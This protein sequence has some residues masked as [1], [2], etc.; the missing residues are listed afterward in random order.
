MKWTI[1]GSELD[2]LIDLFQASTIVHSTQASATRSAK[3]MVQGASD[4]TG[5]RFSI[6]SAG[7]VT[8]LSTSPDQGQVYYGIQNFAT[9]ELYLSTFLTTQSD[10]YW[11]SPSNTSSGLTLSSWATPYYNQ[12]KAFDLVPTQMTQGNMT[13]PITRELFCD[14]LVK[15]LERTTTF[16]VSQSLRNPFY[17]TVSPPILALQNAGLIGGKTSVQFAPN[18]FLTR[19]EGAAILGK[20][21]LYYNLKVPTGY[22][23]P[24]FAD[25]GK[26]SFWALSSVNYMTALGVMV[27]TNAGFSPHTIFTKEEALVTVMNLYRVRS[28]S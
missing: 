14:L 26:I 9:F 16:S 6:D 12:A 25:Q 22:S 20:I 17:D 24:T 15:L 5:F 13:D 4:T 23:Y 7:I 3:Y 11:V 2:N 19:E 18:D 21:A 28:G 1:R 27:G 10:G 8:L